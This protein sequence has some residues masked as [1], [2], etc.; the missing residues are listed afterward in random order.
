MQA[1]AKEHCVTGVWVLIWNK[2]IDSIKNGGVH[3]YKGENNDENTQKRFLAPDDYAF[4]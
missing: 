4:H 2:R 1:Y 3:L